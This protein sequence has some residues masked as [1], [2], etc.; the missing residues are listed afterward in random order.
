MVMHRPMHPGGALKT[1]RA[2]AGGV[3]F[4]LAPLACVA[5]T[6][7]PGGT[8]PGRLEQ[9]FA[10]PPEPRP[11][12]QPDIQLGTD[13]PLP[14]EA[15]RIRF[16]VKGLTL[17]GTTALNRREVDAL[18]GNYAGRE[19]SLAEIYA[20]ADKLTAHYRNLGYVL[21]RVLV[22]EQRIVDGRLKLVAVEGY[23]DRVVFEG[24][25]PAQVARLQPYAERLKFSRPL[26]AQVLERSLL[27]MNDLSGSH[28]RAIVRAST[29]GQGAADLVIQFSAR[30][31]SASAEVNNRG[32]RTLGPVTMLGHMQWHSPIGR[33][34]ELRFAL[35]A[36]PNDELRFA[37]L[38][39]SIP[40]GSDGL[41]LALSTS[42][43]RAHPELEGGIDVRTRSTSGALKLSYPVQ[44][45][46]SRNFY[47]HGGL[48][49]QDGRTEVSGLPLTRD[50]VKTFRLGAAYDS[51][52]AWVGINTIELEW[53]RGL[54]VGNATQANAADSSRVGAPP[55]FSKTTL[56]LARLQSLRVRWD[57][58]AAVTAQA[59]SS[60]LFS[61]EQFGFGG[62]SFGRAYD[63]SELLGD[64]GA[65]VK[66]E[67]RYAMPVWS[68]ATLYGFCEA[69]RVR[70][71]DPQNQPER[72]SAADFGAGL[73]FGFGQHLG[74]YLEV[75]KPATRD[76]EHSNDRKAR[77]FAAVRASF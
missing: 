65:A 49:S 47:L 1:A 10:R 23:V 77:V 17:E 21:T 42:S 46:R 63:A 66:L 61:S 9:P 62:A 31:F 69:G 48:T 28:A 73:R 3:I 12:P 19:V 5:Q 2:W 29:A 4:L 39:Y 41:N 37:S 15:N 18:F 38:G 16:T 36:T 24:A 27:L 13:L 52:D 60:K 35:A 22:P 59:S 72:E 33:F 71:R 14:D 20:L 50:V 43:A 55:D 32:S 34:D 56:Y 44:R 8:Q 76:S 6:V 68:S 58:L 74:G 45:S 75:A 67:L 26:T 25:T 57:L 64:T 53:V 40:L 70:R 7:L 30:A 11:A 51:T 54:D